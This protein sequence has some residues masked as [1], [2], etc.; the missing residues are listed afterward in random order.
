MHFK[1][2]NDVAWQE[3]REDFNSLKVLRRASLSDQQGGMGNAFL[4]MRIISQ[5]R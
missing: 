1:Q 4:M 5:N 3:I 2:V